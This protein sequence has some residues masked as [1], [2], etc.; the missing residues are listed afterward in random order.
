[1]LSSF[2]NVGIRGYGKTP[3]VY[4]LTKGGHRLLA[5]TQEDMGIEPGPHRPVNVTTRWSPMMYHRLATIDVMMA[6]ERD[7]QALR[8][9]H[10]PKTFVEY[11]REKIEGRLQRETTDYVANRQIPENRIV[12]DAGFVLEHTATEKRALFLVEVDC[13]TESLTAT[14]GAREAQTIAHKI[15]QY[16]RY[17]VSKRATERYQAWGDFSGFTLL[18]ITTSEK[19]LHNMRDAT[20][21]TNSGFYR[22]Y[23]LSVLDT[24]VEDFF[25]D[26]W[27]SRDTTDHETYKLMRGS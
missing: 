18:I 21:S 27:Y 26:G 3:K 25:H 8:E 6:L 2:G 22:F 24:V 16:D 11:R 5:E 4:F 1:M 13:G 17:L 20:R 23:R 14:Q 12:P 9:Y 7:G 10:I 15:N 19:R